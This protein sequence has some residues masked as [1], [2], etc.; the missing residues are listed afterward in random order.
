MRRGPAGSGGVTETPHDQTWRTA[1]EEGGGW[2]LRED[3][4][5]HDGES[6]RSLQVTA[7]L[8]LVE[9]VVRAGRNQWKVTAVLPGREGSRQGQGRG[10]SGPVAARRAP[11][12][13]S[14]P[15]EVPYR[16][17][18]EKTPEREEPGPDARQAPLRFRG[19]PGQ[20]VVVL[21]AFVWP[22]ALPVR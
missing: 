9:R 17:R 4:R 12:R 10:R 3:G 14:D 13:P 18:E 2:Y 8:V 1:A 7:G 11:R 20:E 19:N 15:R 5:R 21:V 6:T 16:L 22:A